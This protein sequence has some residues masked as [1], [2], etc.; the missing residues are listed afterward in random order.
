MPAFISSAKEHTLLQED[1]LL[2]LYSGNKNQDTVGMGLYINF[3][4]AFY[5]F[6]SYFNFHLFQT[7]SITKLTLHNLLY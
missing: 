3:T 1:T 5:F 4:I 6:I 2:P 7:Y